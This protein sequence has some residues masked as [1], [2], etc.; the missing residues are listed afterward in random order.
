MINKIIGL[1]KKQEDIDYNLKGYKKLLTL[2]S[3]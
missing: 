2:K 3:F 1:V